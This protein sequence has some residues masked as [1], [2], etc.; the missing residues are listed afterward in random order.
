MSN[1]KE[2]VLCGGTFF[3]LLLRARK[4]RFAARRNA[5]GD[6][7]G[8]SDQDVF[9]GLIK[10]AF[11]NF[12][13][14]T[15]N[16][17]KT[18]TSNYK[19]CK[20]S[21]NEYLQFGNSELIA[22]FNDIVVGPYEPALQRMSSFIEDYIAAEDY[23]NWLVNAL[24]ELIECDAGT[25]GG[26]F[27]IE[28]SQPYDKK[29][30]LQVSEVDLAS[31]LLGIWHYIV[32]Q[33]TDNKIG[34]K[35]YEEWHNKPDSP[36]AKRN[37]ISD[38]GRNKSKQINV[39]IMH[40]EQ[41]TDEDTE[42]N[43]EEMAMLASVD[44]VIPEIT[45]DPNDLWIALPKKMFVEKEEFTEYL[46]NA[47][48]KYDKIKTLLYSDAPRKFY[49][50]YVCNNIS[51]KI[52][53]KKYTYRT[54]IIS[55]ATAETLKEC[56]NFILISGT[57]GLGKS[58]M[59]RHL[60]LDSISTYEEGSQL[61]VFIP[62]KDYAD[63]YENL[64]DYVY[65]K[66]ESLCGDGDA[67]KYE[68]LLRTGRFLLLFDGLDEI[69]SDYRKKFEHDLEIFADKYSENMFV[70]SSRPTGSF[71]SFH[72]FTVLD[73]CPFTKDQATELIEKL[74]FRPDEPNIK[75]QFLE[76]LQSKLFITHR[77]FTE[78]PLLLTIMLM[79][80]EQFADI[81]SKMHVFY[82]E[83]YVAMSQKHDASKGAFKRAL[84]TGLTADQFADYLAEFCARTYRDEK[85]EF[86]DIL[87]DKYF[88]DM[89]LTKKG[90]SGVTAQDFRDDL[91]ENMCLMYYESGKYHFTHR[92]FQEYFCAW[93]F[94]KQKDKNL[95]AIGK[96]FENKRY[97][98]VTD[99]TF[100]MLY[101]MIP[102][103][104][105]EYIFE[106]FLENLFDECEK[107]EGYRTFLR[108]MYP[109]LYYDTGEAGDESEN[110]PESFL[111]DFIIKK[112]HICAYYTG[113]GLPDDEEF[114]TK[115][116]VYLDE[117]YNDP[118]ID[119][120]GLIEVGE[121]PYEYKCEYG[122]PAVVGWNYEIEVDHIF[123][124]PSMY[125]G[126]IDILENREFPLKQ[127]YDQV[128]DYLEELRS[129]KETVGDDLFDLFQ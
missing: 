1:N 83:A 61:P 88:N 107:E 91:V 95:E 39:S 98:Q 59:M 33:R 51:Q 18:Y 81:P 100:S 49:D 23:A 26:L 30:L 117:E 127:E 111:Y 75:K 89:H 43:Q 79:T 118:D 25:D 37:F 35:T 67:A 87:F 68:D 73:L 65:E 66:F 85:F 52:Y 62:L 121:I 105:D 104:V 78:N 116:W 94:S 80:Y 9:E 115:E 82:R 92:S 14:P 48:E 56:S 15:G 20:L 126:L 32:T 123:S 28:G 101:D 128:R 119:T 74:D 34:A 16:S 10:V 2:Y 19:A 8:L 31:F 47:K 64:S 86:T 106:P 50:F 84:K 99:K 44:G 3:T 110:V 69:K 76:E 7:D 113:D 96:F 129:K 12:V 70:I 27:Y 42:G 77:E 120:D 11:P 102:D 57:G 103:K 13:A 125:E 122:E 6:R 54:K 38:I 5:D 41:E 21:S 17:F 72:R 108:K 60:L 90:T 58:M 22:N 112:E 71:I 53:L 55:N 24:L 93:Y 40:Y 29:H 124:H 45:G 46:K 4:Q 36:R 63:T 109:V 97:R 114:L